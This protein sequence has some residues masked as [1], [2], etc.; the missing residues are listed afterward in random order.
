MS[1]EFTPAEDWRSILLPTELGPDSEVGFAHAVRLALAARA[2]LRVVHVH[3]SRDAVHW[4]M[5]PQLRALLAR[6]GILGQDATVSDF[7]HLGIR[8]SFE[9]LPLD[10]PTVDGV[11]KA[12]APLARDLLVVETHPRASWQHLRRWSTAERIALT[13]STPALFLPIEQR[14]FLD[15]DTGELRIRRV[16]IPVAPESAAQESVDMAASLLDLLAVEQVEI[17]LLHVGSGR[18]LPELRLHRRPGW[19]WSTDVCWGRVASAILQSAEDH[20]ADLLV[21]A[22]HGHDGLLDLLVGSTT[23]QVIRAAPCP[24]LALPV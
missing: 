15:T 19:S 6:W 17:T 18:G 23:E 12:V 13:S 1:T 24:L 11:P 4:E 9:D 14:G 5:I 10:Q 7:E 8:V 3:P 22:T 21:M 16:I 20:Q 2:H